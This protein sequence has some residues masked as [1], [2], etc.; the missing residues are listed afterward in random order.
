MN[1]R[2]SAARKQ[3]SLIL[4][5]VLVL[6]SMLLIVWSPNGLLH[7]RQLHLEYQELTKKNLVLEKENYQLYQE[8]ILLRNDTAAIERLARQELGLVK[9]GELIFQFVSPAGRNEVHAK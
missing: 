3:L 5:S 4:W 1:R 9:E 6:A 2:L 7:L 8:I